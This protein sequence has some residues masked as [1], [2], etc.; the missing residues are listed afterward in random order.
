MLDRTAAL[1]TRKVKLNKGI[2]AILLGHGT[3]D[4]GTSYDASKTWFNEQ[5]SVEDKEFKTYEGWS[6]QLHADLPDNRGVYAKDVADWILA[7]SGDVK[8]SPVVA[9]L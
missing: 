4:L 7:R 5:T 2:Q 9:K 6:H 1:N 8:S 3:A